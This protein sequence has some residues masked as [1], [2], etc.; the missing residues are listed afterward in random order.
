M[1]MPTVADIITWAKGVKYTALSDTDL[2][3]DLN[4]IQ[5]EIYLDLNV[6]GC[7]FGYPKIHQ[8][9]TTTT[10]EYGLPEDCRIE[11]I[12]DVEISTVPAGSE[13]KPMDYYG[14]RELPMYLQHWSKGTTFGTIKITPDTTAEGYLIKIRYSPS[15]VSLTLLSQTP[16]LDERYHNLYRYALV[17]VIASKGDNPDTEIANYYEQEY[18]NMLE[19]VK[20]DLASRQTTKPDSIPQTDEWW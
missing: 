14:L 15:P 3:E 8:I 16:S 11:N 9:T 2:L 5:D 6:Y 4:M 7:G 18:L 1:I 13:F 17:Q 19:K 12:T 10:T 20:V